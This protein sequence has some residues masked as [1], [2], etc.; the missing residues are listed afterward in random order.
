MR[1]LRFVAAVLVGLSVP[2][3]AAGPAQADPMQS[4]VDAGGAES[5]SR[6]TTAGI[7]VIDRR[8]GVHSDNGPAARLRFGSASLVKLFIAENLLRRARLGEITLTQADRDA[9][10]RMLRSSD[11]A[12]A[13]SFWSRFG[14]NAIVSD[15]VARYGLTGTAPPANPR[16]W[17]LTQVTARDM[18]LFYEGVLSGRGGLDPADRDV[19]MGHLRASTARG[20]DGVY[21]WFGL[22]DA[23]P[24]EPV[25][26]L[27]QGWMCC[28]SDGYTWRHSAGVVGPD[29]RYV[30]VVLT[31]DPGG[32]GAA[33]T[34]QSATRIVQR[35]FPAGL[36]PRVHG[37][38]GDRWYAMGG[39]GSLLGLPVRD[40]VPLVRGGAMTPF[41]RG[42]MWWSP[43]TGTRWVIGAVL[44][45]YAATGWEAGPLG[46]PTT[47]EIRLAGGA[48]SGFEGGA[49][50]WSPA[51]GAHW[52]DHATWQAWGRQG[53][54]TGRLGYPT[55]DRTEQPDG[56]ALTA[57]RGGA[58]AW[59]AGTGARWLE[60]PVLAGWQAQGGPD[61][62]LGYPTS[63]RIALAGGAFAAFEGGAVYWSPGSGAHW[64]DHATWQAWGRQGWETGRLGYPTGDRTELPGGGALTTFTGGAV[65]WS[66]ATG[67]HWLP[68]PLLR[69]WEEQGRGTGALG[70]PTSDPYPTAEGTR[71]DFTGGALTL[72]PAGR[73]VRAAPAPAGTP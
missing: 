25:I 71:V 35:M 48:F 49:V 32:L 57:F 27:K 23:L 6:G 40:E 44:E 5:Y 43:S 33:H 3:T 34:E 2:L 68:A 66:E 31:R 53:W 24:R 46:Y 16:Y 4:L 63:D 7:A 21:Q 38:I 1:W 30:V 20:T 56:G 62:P 39:S 69:A 72:T 37:A 8:T 61:G 55:G 26:A 50:Y 65:A 70:F 36:V 29:S 11:D 19:I 22:H 17:G 15:V 12:A 13:S 9:M 14:A 51:T 67:A 60:G 59:S 47:D 28:F 54:E 58:V 64:F 42:G 18:A 10:A 45:R 41:E 73:V 52:F